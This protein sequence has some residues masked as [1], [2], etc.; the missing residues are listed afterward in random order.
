MECSVSRLTG[1]A[2]LR[3]QYVFASD[4]WNTAPMRHE[5]FG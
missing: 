1:I 4:N 5:P 2:V 3:L